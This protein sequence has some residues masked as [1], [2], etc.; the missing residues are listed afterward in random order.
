MGA[1]VSSSTLAASRTASGASVGT[2]GELAQGVLPDGTA[3]VVTCPIELGTTVELTTEPAATLEIVG[4]PE[5]RT[6]ISR[7]L[8]RTAELLELPPVRITV[9]QRTALPVGKGMASSTA[10][11]VAA[12]RALAAA[13]GVALTPDE[14]ARLATAFEPSD[15]VMYDGVVVTDRRTGRRLRDWD[16]SPEFTIVVAI[17]S[18]TFSTADA[19]LDGQTRHGGAYAD[20]LVRLDAAAEQRDLGA[21]A[22]EATR[23]GELGRSTAPNETFDRLVREADRVGALGVCTA[24]T[25]TVA[26]LL[27]PR[28]R[29]GDAA[30]RQAKHRL[31]RLL[32]AGH[33]LV[34]TR[35][36]A[37]PH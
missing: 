32:P 26:G 6:L 28:T 3:F 4:I 19:R 5:G 12:S 7:A 24:H 14:L 2:C 18:A 34:V 33:D 20:L 29:A 13:A 35:T 27:F 1:L 15:A 37:A 25:G 36:P 17:P 22:R 23:S 8:K 10:D 30:A 21:F 16:W 11:I 31:R 9:E